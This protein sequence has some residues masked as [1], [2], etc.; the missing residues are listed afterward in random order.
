MDFEQLLYQKYM[1]KM[2]AHFYI[3]TA[4]PHHP[5]PSL[6]LEKWIEGFLLRV[7]MQEKGINQASAQNVFQLGHGDIL[8]IKKEEDTERYLTEDFEELLYFQNYY[9][10][11]FS[12][13][14][15]IVYNAQNI[16]DHVANKLLKTLEEPREG[17]TI[18]FLNSSSQQF[19]PTIRS[20]AIELK[21]QNK[22]KDSLT[23][24]LLDPKERL[25]WFT[26]QIKNRQLSCDAESALC[27][28]LNQQSS[29]QEFLTNK[30]IEKDDW[31]KLLHLLLEYNCCQAT[32]FQQKQKIMDE[33]KWFEQ[34][35]IFGQPQWER[36]LG[37]LK[38]SF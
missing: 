6:F 25:A 32:N 12:H 30:K 24:G 22:N 23:S 36:F 18:I 3:I 31:Q 33:I 27:S 4:P 9:N 21:L 5:T 8:Q 29:E 26:A 38:S 16:T 14:F 37:L 2:L 15:A 17:S 7:I 13:R 10:F 19:L 35:Q 1:Q 28:Y 11:E 20:R 34:S